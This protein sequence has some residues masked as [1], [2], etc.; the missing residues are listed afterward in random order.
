MYSTD[1][2]EYSRS[3]LLNLCFPVIQLQPSPPSC[4][5]SY[6]L[7]WAGKGESI[8]VIPSFMH[9]WGRGAVLKLIKD[10][11]TSSFLYFQAVGSPGMGGQQIT[12]KVDL[13]LCSGRGKQP[14]GD[15]PLPCPYFFSYL[16]KLLFY[17]FLW[18]EEG[19]LLEHLLS[20]T[21]IESGQFLWP[22]IPLWQRWTWAKA[23]SQVNVNM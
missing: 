19:C 9:L 14:S 12:S 13:P 1:A 10:C 16:V 5:S 20:F 11:Q 7:Y 2:W 17:S 8:S 22:F 23:H 21:F 18:E 4:K 15:V 6:L 3:I